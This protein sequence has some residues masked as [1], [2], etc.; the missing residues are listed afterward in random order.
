MSLMNSRSHATS[1]VNADGISIDYISNRQ[2]TMNSLSQFYQKNDFQ[3]SGF[4]TGRSCV[5]T[6]WKAYCQFCQEYENL[7]VDVGDLK[8]AAQLAITG[9]AA[10]SFHEYVDVK[11]R[12]RQT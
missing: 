3:Y 12:N 1:R 2:A 5:R 4:D 7:E 10:S 9:H 6:S 11:D 8:N